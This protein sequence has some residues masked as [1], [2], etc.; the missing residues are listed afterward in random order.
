MM[1]D[2]RLAHVAA[3]REVA[4]A[5]LA[6]PHQLAHDRKAGRVAKGLEELDVR[7]DDGGLRSCHASIISTIIYIDKYQYCAVHFMEQSRKKGAL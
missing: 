2:R 6:R 4:G 7:I 3:S 1:R 5:D